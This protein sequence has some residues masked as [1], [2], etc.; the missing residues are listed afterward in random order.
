M[1]VI[2]VFFLFLVCS[3]PGV[4]A[5][6]LIFV[7]MRSARSSEGSRYKILFIIAVLLLAIV[8]VLYFM[9]M[10]EVSALSETLDE[11]KA[12]IRKGREREKA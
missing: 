5:S 7:A 4:G 11:A 9:K 12:G 8:V 3:T 6:F 10:Q 1:N 2:V